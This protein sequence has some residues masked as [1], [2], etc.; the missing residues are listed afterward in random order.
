MDNL[1]ANIMLPASGVHDETACL[2]IINK[3]SARYILREI[4]H[5]MK[6]YIY[7]ISINPL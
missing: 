1:F 4:V 7:E 2:I 3:S 5:N 6:F